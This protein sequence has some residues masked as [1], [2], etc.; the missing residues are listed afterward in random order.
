MTSIDTLDINSLSK[1]LRDRLPDLKDDIQAEKFAGGQSN[2]TFLLTSGARKLVLRRKPPGKLLKSAHAVDREFKVLNA[3][4]KT[5][6]PV[7]RPLL[8][9]ED[10]D[11][12]G[13]MFFVMS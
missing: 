10:D 9:C 2:P 5:E 6:I 1:Y 11:V 3:L 12:I 4:S 8:L 13:S 7:A